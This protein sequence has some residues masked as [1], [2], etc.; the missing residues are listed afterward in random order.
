MTNAQKI[1][2]LEKKV[3]EQQEIING[4]VGA[5]RRVKMCYARA[6]L[7]QRNTEQVRICENA[8]IVQYSVD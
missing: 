7:N 2:A 5:S 6:A 4:Y 8:A 3:R 1:A